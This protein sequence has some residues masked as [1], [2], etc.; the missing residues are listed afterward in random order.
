[1]TSPR[2]VVTAVLVLLAQLVDVTLLGRLQVEGA[3][4]DLLLLVVV[5]AALSGGTVHGA[6]VGVCAGLLADVTPP[7][8]GLLGV[9]ALAYAAAGA[10]AGRWY[11]PG[12]RTTDRPLL[13]AVVAAGAAAV[14]MTLVQTVFALSA[15]SLQH[16]LLSCAVAAGAA[17]VLGAVVLPVLHALDRRVAEEVL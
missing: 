5:A 12:G 2:V 13:L 10:L 9:H 8:A 7:A 4:P 14:L 3:G 15:Q 11:R 6:T 16:V 17:V 1:V